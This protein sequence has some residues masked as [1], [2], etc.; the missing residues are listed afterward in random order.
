[1]GAP[2]AVR[3][4]FCTVVP[5]KEQGSQGV[6]SR[7]WSKVSNKGF[8]WWTARKV[9]AAVWGRRRVCVC[10]VAT[11][12]SFSQTLELCVFKT[13]PAVLVFKWN[14]QGISKLD[15]WEGGSSGSRDAYGSRSMDESLSHVTSYQQNAVGVHNLKATQG[16][17]GHLVIHCFCF[18]SAGWIIGLVVVQSHMAVSRL[19]K[20]LEFLSFVAY[21]C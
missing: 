19:F 14:C 17:L 18:S 15:W 9:H 21:K 1:M 5:W 13:S 8:L 7:C 10:S 6:V 12:L 2:W 20:S 11:N 4:C 16:H 3:A